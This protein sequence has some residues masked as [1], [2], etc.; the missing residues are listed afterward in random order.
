MIKAWP[1][2]DCTRHIP[3]AFSPTTTLDI[4]E[5]DYR[6]YMVEGWDLLKEVYIFVIV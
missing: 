1:S 5:N 3:L 6:K 4:G 2:I